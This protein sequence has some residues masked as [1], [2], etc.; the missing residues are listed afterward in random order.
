MPFFLVSV[1]TLWDFVTVALHGSSTRQSRRRSA[2]R[3]PFMCSPQPVTLRRNS[4]FLALF[5]RDITFLRTIYA[6]LRGI[7]GAQVHT[8]T[9][10]WQQDTY[11]GTELHHDHTPTTLNRLSYVSSHVGQIALTPLLRESVPAAFCIA[12]V[13]GWW[14]VIALTTEIEAAIIGHLFATASQFLRPPKTACFVN[15]LRL[16]EAAHTSAK[17]RY[18]QRP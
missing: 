16:G 12:G 14:F 18:S 13:E 4:S 1:W 6:N 3:S 10:S 5:L 11:E 17:A 2:R 9:S 8:V 15:M 7:Q